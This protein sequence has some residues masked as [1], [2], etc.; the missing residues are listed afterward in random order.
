MHRNISFSPLSKAISRLAYTPQ[1]SILLYAFVC[2]SPLRY[3]LKCN[4]KKKGVQIEA[5][6][7]CCPLWVRQRLCIL[8]R[9]IFPELVSPPLLSPWAPWWLVTTNRPLRPSLGDGS[10]CTE[11]LGT[12][13]FTARTQ[14]AIFTQTYISGLGPWL[15]VFLL[16]WSFQLTCGFGFV[17]FQISLPKK[18]HNTNT[19]NIIYQSYK[20]HN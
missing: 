13:N 6:H 17:M 7:V 16:Q 2:F 20:I 4:C 5:Q 1:P 10:S 12:Y 19:S 8:P 18:C 3:L 9:T 14:K 11:S 15:T